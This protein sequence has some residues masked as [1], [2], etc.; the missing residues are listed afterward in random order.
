[1]IRP[2]LSFLTERPFAHRG[3]HGR[4]R[5][6][7]GMAAFD[8]A[9]QAGFGI[10]C[11]IRLS[12][13]GVPMVFHDATLARMTGAEGRLD[14]RMAARIDALRL[15]DGGA[16]PRLSA[17]LARTGYATP[18]LIEL[19]PGH[20]RAGPLC[21]AVAAALDPW[22]GAPVAVMSF[23]PGAVHWFAQHRPMQARGLV[24]TARDKGYWRGRAERTLALWTTKPDFLACDVRDLSSLSRHARRAGL[25]VLSWTVRTRA[26]RAMAHALAD[27]IIFEDSDD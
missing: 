20:R 8:A 23:H 16:I 1:M 18:V 17:L 7:N 11:D 22:P 9:I 4:G 24:L 13:N 19:K 26:E 14:A 15:P 5:S 6:E 25:P 3:L 10:E 12:R 21:R 2:D 27:Q